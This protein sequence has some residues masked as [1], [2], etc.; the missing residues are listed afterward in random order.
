[1]ELVEIFAYL[2][3]IVG[4]LMAF[5][6]F[7]QARTIYANKSSKD[8]SLVNYIVLMVGC[9]IW[10]IYGILKN[11]FPIMISFG[12]SVLGTTAV[13]ALKFIYK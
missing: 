11:D 9:W 3:G 1:M 12:I 8:V 2:T 6:H 5:G 13:V 4:I 10:L 7:F